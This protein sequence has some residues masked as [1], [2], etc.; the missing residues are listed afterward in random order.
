MMQN[1]NNEKAKHRSSG[2]VSRLAKSRTGNTVVILAAAFVPMAAFVGAGF[3]MSRSY[4]VKSRLQTACDSGALAARREMVGATW[5]TTTQAAADSYFDANF[6]TGRYGTTGLVRNF[7]ATDGET[8]RGTASVDVPTTI[9]KMFGNDVVKVD[10]DCQAIMNLPNTDVMFVLDTTGSMNEINPG[11]STS[12]IVSLRSAVGNFHS[13]IETAKSAG[14]QVRYGFVPYSSN[15]NVGFLLKREWM[16]NNWT[17][18]SRE[19]NT[20]ELKSNVGGEL[21]TSSYGAD[22]T[23][24]SGDRALVT[25]SLPI[26]KCVAPSNSIT[27]SPS[28]LLSETSE[29]FAGPPAGTKTTKVYKYT[30]DGVRYS[31]NQTATS[32]TLYT[33][34]FDDYVEEYKYI[35][36]PVLTESSVT[37]DYY[38]DYKPVTFDV[39]GLKGSNPSGLMAGGSVIA[40]VG[41]NHSAKTVN[42]NGCIEERATVRDGSFSP[43][44]TD[45]LDLNIDAIPNPAD[46][47]TQWRPALAGLVYTRHGPGNWQMADVSHTT[48]NYWNIEDYNSGFHSV[49]P[50]RAARMESLTGSQINSY[51]STLV[52]AGNTYHDIG[53]IWGLRLLSPTGIFAADNA[54]TPAGKEIVR[55][56][57]FMTDGETETDITNYD[58]Y[59]LSALDRRRTNVASLPS[60]SDTNT[61]V[62]ERL[63]GLCE[64]AKS[65]NITVWVIA[66]GT[67]LTTLLE[68]CASEGSA[69]EA[70]NTAELNTTFSEIASKIANLRLN[71]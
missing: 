22:W 35:T 45:A 1:S 28:T 23:K 38:W 39:S 62:E 64:S 26:E 67:S 52:P 65:R 59:G 25:T 30:V 49:C 29:G 66:F 54:L 71:D 24:L 21:T 9:M 68:N 58:A 53:M 32:C 63:A 70:N 11:D 42:W 4:L 34:T 60:N 31:I 61:Q 69:F 50:A 36:I 48:A 17:Y 16:V 8:V 20:T 7:S 33:E 47:N 57:I 6:Q 56:L 10:V 2:L 37:T 55:H 13:A 51:L 27:Y 40:T 5:G 3:D 46:P 18:Q 19:A 12:R 41:N 43:I 44:P 14:T 15:V